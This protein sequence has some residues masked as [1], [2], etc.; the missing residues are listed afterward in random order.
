MVPLLH[1]IGK[2]INRSRYIE[3]TGDITEY[4]VNML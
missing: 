1:S 4:A 3:V 2:H